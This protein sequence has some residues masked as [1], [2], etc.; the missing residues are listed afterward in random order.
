MSQAHSDQDV[1]EDVDASDLDLD[2]TEKVKFIL[3]QIT[4]VHS[5]FCPTVLLAAVVTE[6]PHW[7]CNTVCLSFSSSSKASKTL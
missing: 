2:V 5:L 7:L 6:F 1:H 4:A 3:A